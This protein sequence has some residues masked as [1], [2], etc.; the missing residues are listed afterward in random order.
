MSDDPKTPK[1]EDRTLVPYIILALM[2]FGNVAVLL[3]ALAGP[4]GPGVLTLI[5][6]GIFISF[7][8]VVAK[9]IYFC[10]L[11]KL[12][13]SWIEDEEDEGEWQLESEDEDIELL[14]YQGDLIRL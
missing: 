11:D 1:Q 7:L 5:I 9:A 4:T 2:L 8:F 13:K 10:G 6:Y 14:R 3:N 12:C